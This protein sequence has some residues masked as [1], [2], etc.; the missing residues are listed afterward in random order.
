MTAAASATPSVLA[1][2]CAGLVGLGVVAYAVFGGADFGAGVWDLL[3]RGP[4]AD[5]QREAISHALG[6]VWEANNVWL[7]YV[8]VVTWT[9]F[10][11]VY[12]SVSTAL[13]IPIVLA[14]VGIVLRGAGFGLRSQYARR[15]GIAIAWGYAFNGASV[16]APFMLGALAGGIAGGD[17][18]VRD[19]VVQANLWTTWTTPFA[20]ACGA[21]AVGL[22]ATLAATYLAVE[23]EAANDG[24]LLEDFRVRALIAGAVTAALG[25]IAAVLGAFESSQL[26]SG[27]IGK[28]LPLSLG[29]TLIGLLTAFALLW[30]RFV[31]ARYLVAGEMACVLAAWAVAQYPYLIIPDVTI[32]NAAAPDSVLLATVLATAAGMVILLPSLWYL[33]SIF[34]GRQQPTQQ[35]T[36]ATLADEG[37]RIAFAPSPEDEQT[38]PRRRSAT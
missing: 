12:A 25:A 23:A 4:R 10:P 19:G 21:F 26:W 35:V 27:L 18:R 11:I 8:I 36:A 16:I 34:K 24:D 22:S 38:T 3:A 17:I 13:F 15:A 33:F 31:W 37:L 2:I 29:A 30:G 7:I 6:P 1:I 9:C 28:A 20:L 32:A 5:R 14:L